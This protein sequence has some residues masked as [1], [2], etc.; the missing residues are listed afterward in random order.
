MPRANKPRY[1]EDRDAWVTKIDGRLVTLAKGRRGRAEADRELRRLLTAKDTQAPPSIAVAELCDRLL[2]WVRENRSP[3]TLEWYTRHLRGFADHV[4]RETPITAVRPY[5]VD[6]WLEGRGWGQ[7]TQAG[8]ITAVKRAFRW[9]WRKGYLPTDPLAGLD[10]PR[11]PRREAILS[12]EQ[13]RAVLAAAPGPLRDYLVVI[14]ETGCRPSEVARM[15]AA[16]VAGDVVSMRS[17]TSEATGRVRT[18]Y[19]TPTAAETISRLATKRPD[20]PIFVNTRGRPWTRNALALAMGR[21]RRKLKLGPECVAESFRHGWVTDAKLKLPNSVVAELAG[22]ASTAMVDRHYSH[23]NERKAELAAALARVRGS[24]N[25][26][27]GPADA[28]GA[29]PG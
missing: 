23:L 13:E 27:G 5:H 17:K 16:H 19:L 8:A 6:R 21:I 12:P 9:G 15:E 14:H 4:G 3:L 11:M 1:R 29:T 25:D 20:G 2:V 22:H 7:A 10:K 24:R 28:S 26:S 18:I